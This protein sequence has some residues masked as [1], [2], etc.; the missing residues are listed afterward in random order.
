MDSKQGKLYFSLQS[1]LIILF[2]TVILIRILFLHFWN[3]GSKRKG[4]NEKEQERGRDREK[5]GYLK[6]LGETVDCIF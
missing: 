5:A 3:Q 1:S 6:L 2:S 4:E